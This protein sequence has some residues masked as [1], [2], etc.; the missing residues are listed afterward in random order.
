MWRN[1]KRLS[2]N[3]SLKRFRT[4]E[5]RTKKMPM[6]KKGTPEYEA[7]IITPEYKK[8][9][10]KV[11]ENTTG[12]KNPNFGKRGGAGGYPKKG[13]PEYDAWILTSEY[14]EH[15]RKSSENNTGEKHPMWKKHHTVEARKKMSEASTG[16]KNHFFGKHH[17]KESLMLIVIAN[18]D[19]I[20]SVETRN[21]LSTIRTGSHP[22][23][24]TR[25]KNSIANSGENN[26]MFG[27]TGE[28]HWNW[29]GEDFPRKY[30]LKFNKWFK[31]QIR[32]DYGNVCFFPDCEITPKENGRELDIHHY[33][34]DKNSLN[35]VPLCRK[36]NAAVNFNRE[37][38]KKFFELK[39]ILFW[40]TKL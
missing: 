3:F 39:V 27:V 17:T 29:K 10:R 13:T 33:D 16:E 18:T 24:E 26:P 31:L 30:P 15:C 4:G 22:T 14:K 35:C 19:R 5:R 7:W 28:N 23:E 1:E 32:S 25:L 12:D 38:W 8:F 2:C 11:S 40:I 21:L 9:C 34:Y 37:T 20:V 36:H 6:Y